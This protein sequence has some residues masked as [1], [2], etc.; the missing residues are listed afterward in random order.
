MLGR[1]DGGVIH[2]DIC[3]IAI[4]LIY[5][6]LSPLAIGLD[7]VGVGGTGNGV[8]ALSFNPLSRLQGDLAVGDDLFRLYKGRRKSRKILTRG[9]MLQEAC[10]YSL[11]SFL[12]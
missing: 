8:P 10:K 2:T 9:K 12:S 7:G 4:T 5:W 1:G 6:T 3:Y 11:M